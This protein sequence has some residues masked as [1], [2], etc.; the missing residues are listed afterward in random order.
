FELWRSYRHG[1]KGKALVHEWT[2]T[3]SQFVPASLSFLYWIANNDATH[4]TINRFG[5]L[6][7][8]LAALVS[9][10]NFGN[11]LIDIPTALFLAFVLV[12][13]RTNRFVTL[14]PALKIPLLLLTLV[15]V[16]MPSHLFGVWGT[17]FRLPPIL[18]CILIAGV[19]IQPEGWRPIRFIVIAGICL[20]AT[21]S[22]GIAHYWQDTDQ[23]FRE[24]KAATQVLNP[25]GKLLVVQ[26]NDDLPDD[27]LIG[28]SNLFWHLGAL[29]V[30]ERSNFFPF[31]FTGHSAVDSAPATKLID[32]PVGTPVTRHTLA[33]D[34]DPAKSKYSVGDY[35]SRYFRTY[36][37][38]WPDHFDYVLVVRF[39][40]QEN[41]YPERLERTF[42]GSYFDIFRVVPARR[43]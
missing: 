31:L 35:L 1:L 33:A 26:D 23:K 39:D 28:Y 2:V 30:I 29:A 15:T 40:N 11:P 9:P 38:G 6:E 7:D 16:L 42:S 25:G 17:D 34:A 32:T 37:V 3:A 41:P 18:G 14:A 36:W 8:K 19:S 13:C 22:F 20:F 10:A 24:F 12:F 5:S 4:N 27:K 43:P 21:R